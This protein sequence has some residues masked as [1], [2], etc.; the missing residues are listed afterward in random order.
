MSS[1]R[2]TCSNKMIHFFQ[3]SGD[4]TIPCHGRIIYLPS[5]N[6]ASKDGSATMEIDASDASS[7]PADKGVDARNSTSPTSDSTGQIDGDEVVVNDVDHRQAAYKVAPDA[8]HLHPVTRF[9]PSTVA[10]TVKFAEQT[11]KHAGAAHGV[12]TLALAG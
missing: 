11:G 12:S 8:S 4:V 6:V 5:R 7:A 3:R 2:S 9:L 10:A 1:P